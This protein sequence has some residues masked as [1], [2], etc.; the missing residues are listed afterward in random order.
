[1]LRDVSFVVV[2]FFFN[3]CLGMD[4]SWGRELSSVTWET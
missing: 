3:E 2:F 4:A 1:M